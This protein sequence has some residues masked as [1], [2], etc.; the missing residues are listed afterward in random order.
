M[1]S[2][3]QKISLRDESRAWIQGGLW[4]GAGGVVANMAFLAASIVLGRVLQREGFGSYQ[5]FQ[6]LI[7]IMAVVGLPGFYNALIQSLAR[8][9][10]GALR[11]LILPRVWG[12]AAGAILLFA[13]AGLYSGWPH[14]PLNPS[15]VVL[16]GIVFFITNPASLW[17]PALTGKE[18]FVSFGVLR[19]IQA[20]VHSLF[21]IGT[22]VITRSTAATIC[23]AALAF[24]I[25]ECGAFVWVYSKIPKRP[26]DKE[27]VRYGFK[28][29]LPAAIPLISQYLDR[30]II[31][32][33]LGAGPLGLYAVAAT[34]PEGI[35]GFMGLLQGLAVSRLSR[36]SQAKVWSRVKTLWPILTIISGGLGG[37]CWMAA[38]FLIKHLYGPT[39]G[40]ASDYAKWLFVSITI[41][42]AFYLITAAQQAAKKT[43]GFLFLTSFESILEI[44]LMVLGATSHGIPGLVAGKVL[45]RLLSL[46]V[47]IGWVIRKGNTKQNQ[48]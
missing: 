2:E 13:L 47:A 48:T 23:A 25:T 21:V 24:V 1:E 4:V 11:Q 7:L 19:F 44:V 15:L 38:P 40:D 22:A 14:P 9:R 16:A 29:S 10:N 46:V 27:V 12:G 3:R 43:K 18:W 42:P 28:L 37:L 33:L 6:G 17:Q 31:G 35:R 32:S 26:E 41:Y 39:Y 45:A 34:L 36:L 20:L 30:I 5:F 8:G